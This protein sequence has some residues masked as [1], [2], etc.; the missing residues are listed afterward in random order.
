MD[1]RFFGITSVC[2]DKFVTNSFSPQFLS[3]INSEEMCASTEYAATSL[4]L[5]KCNLQPNTWDTLLDKSKKILLSFDI[6]EIL[7]LI[8]TMTQSYSIMPVS[9]FS[10]EKDEGT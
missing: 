3:H 1:V 9:Q 6:R 7:N 5:S 8:K 2:F 10:I 4:Y